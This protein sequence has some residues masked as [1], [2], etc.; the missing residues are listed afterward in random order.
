MLRLATVLLVVIP[1]LGG[2]CGA[3]RTAS[4]APDL[5]VPSDQAAPRDLIQ[6]LDPCATV[7][8]GPPPRCGEPCTEVCGCCWCGPGEPGCDPIQHCIHA[9][10]GA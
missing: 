4:P 2:G 9:D 6:A 5:A 3:G 1:V 8:C 7:G 10:G